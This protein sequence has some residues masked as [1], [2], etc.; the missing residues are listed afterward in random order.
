[1]A[2]TSTHK[3]KQHDCPAPITQSLQIRCH[4][5]SLYTLKNKAFLI[6]LPLSPARP[7]KRASKP[8]RQNMPCNIFTKHALVHCTQSKY[9]NTLHSLPQLQDPFVSLVLIL[10]SERSSVLFQSLLQPS[11]PMF[12]FSISFNLLFPPPHPKPH[13]LINNF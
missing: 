12:I 10:V 7:L 2:N 6:R 4:Q 5:N 9:W 8:T 13:N 3:H 11:P 1:M